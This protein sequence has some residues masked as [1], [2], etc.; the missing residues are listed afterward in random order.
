MTRM[1]VLFLYAVTFA[2]L[3]GNQRELAREK[4]MRK[5]QAKKKSTGAADKEGNKGMTLEERRLRYHV[6]VDE[7]LSAEMRGHSKPNKKQRPVLPRLV[8]LV[9]ANKQFNV[10]ISF[11]S[12]ANIINFL[13]VS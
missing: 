3:G 7:H 13:L 2:L 1:S 8:A 11:V 4:Q 9:E 10:C 5:E 6:I 12:D